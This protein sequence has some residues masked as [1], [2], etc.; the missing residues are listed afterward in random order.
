M[1]TRSLAEQAEVLREWSR[2]VR[3]AS[4]AACAHARAL[5]MEIESGERERATAR[6][7]RAASGPERLPERP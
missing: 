2:E 4:R 3:E 1:P 5:L 6:R 7:A